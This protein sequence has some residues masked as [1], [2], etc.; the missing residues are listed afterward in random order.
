MFIDEIVF[1]SG[2]F[3]HTDS[4]SKVVVNKGDK[5]YV[6]IYFDVKYFYLCKSMM[7]IFSFENNYFSEKGHKKPQLEN[8]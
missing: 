6:D 7:D 4:K 1:L 8:Q 2:Q 3:S 5:N